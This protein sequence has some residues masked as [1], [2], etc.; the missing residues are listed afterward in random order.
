MV[1]LPAVLV[2]VPPAM[3]NSVSALLRFV[4]LALPAVLVSKNAVRPPNSLM[5]VAVPAVLAPKKLV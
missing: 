1:A 5:M 2:S 3:P 4:M